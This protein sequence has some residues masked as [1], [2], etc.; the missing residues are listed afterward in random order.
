MTVLYQFDG[1]TAHTYS[2]IFWTLLH[3]S[4]VFQW[5]SG[6]LSAE[7][8]VSLSYA[9]VS[10]RPESQSL[11]TISGDPAKLSKVKRASHLEP[12]KPT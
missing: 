5:G 3:L 10:I 11:G 12:Q 6:C 4:L 2:S 1:D 9:N 8:R 7:H